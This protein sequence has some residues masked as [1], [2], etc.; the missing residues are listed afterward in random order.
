MHVEG[1]GLVAP[2]PRLVQLT[3]NELFALAE[4]AMKRAAYRGYSSKPT[5]WQRGLTSKT[6]KL[7]GLFIDSNAYSI[8][9]GLVG[10]YGYCKVLKVPIDTE[11]REHGDD[12]ADIHAA[13]RIQVKTRTSERFSNSLNR[14]V[15]SRGRLL[16]F[17]FDAFA[18]AE[19]LRNEPSVSLLGWIRTR[20]AMKVGVFA[21]GKVGEHWNLEIEDKH[22]EPVSDLI[23]EIKASA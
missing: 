12:G 23:A 4:L 17:P 11:L 3:T 19:W 18:F 20:R 22:L 14:R 6:L 10:E 1:Q 9:S 5:R 13:L 15:D 8:M 2:S 16:K 7:G 21:K